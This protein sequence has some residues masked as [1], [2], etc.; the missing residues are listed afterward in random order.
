VLFKHFHKTR[1][2]A[3]AMGFYAGFQISGRAEVMTGVAVR[4]LEMDQINRLR[5][6][7]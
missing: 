4:L 6:H 1:T 3:A 7:V 2:F 5:S